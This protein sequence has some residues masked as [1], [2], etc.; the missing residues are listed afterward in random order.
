MIAGFRNTAC[1]RETKRPIANLVSSRVPVVRP[2]KDEGTG[3]PGG[4]HFLQMGFQKLCLS[5]FAVTDSVHPQF[6]KHER[7]IA[8]QV[9]QSAQVTVKNLP[10]VQVYVECDEVSK[11][12]IEIFRWRKISIR[13][14]PLRIGLFRN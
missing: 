10:I 13:N 2:S 9:L 3:Q 12:K 11:R 8:H 1:V 7:L 4:Q 14:Q 5:E 6:A